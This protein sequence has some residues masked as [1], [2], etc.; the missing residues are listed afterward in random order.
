MGL[1]VAHSITSRGEKRGER[2]DAPYLNFPDN[3]LLP[4]PPIFFLKKEISVNN[5]RYISE[6]KSIVAVNTRTRTNQRTHMC[7]Y[8]LLLPFAHWTNF[9]RGDALVGCFFR[10]LHVKFAYE[11][12]RERGVPPGGGE[13]DTLLLEEGWGDVLL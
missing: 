13:Y 9:V 11:R 1:L 10:T 8:P 6:Q 3:N 12:G 2:R 7:Q 5:K 4:F